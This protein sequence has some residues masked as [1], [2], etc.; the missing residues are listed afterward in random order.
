[1]TTNN[2][3]LTNDKM[4]QMLEQNATQLERNN[5]KKDLVELVTRLKLRVEELESYKLIADRVRDLE[6]S[7]VSL[8]QYVRRESIEIHDI[9]ESVK[10]EKLEDTCLDILEQIG[11]GKIKKYRV[12]AC[13]RLK[14]RSK[15]VI[16]F[17]TRKHADQAL[18]KRG[19]LKDAD[20]TKCGLP[21]GH[22]VY[23]NENLCPPLQYLQYLVRHLKKDGKIHNFNLWKGRLTIQL[24]EDG[25]KIQIGHIDDLIDRGLASEDNRSKFVLN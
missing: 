16:R 22:K 20:M 12:H 9:P 23:I 15:T 24:E 14:N 18:W 11:C 1:M 3:G 8:M 17:L 19:N 5:N 13:H 6:R 4:L 25:D 21:A 10:D 2:E 7:Q